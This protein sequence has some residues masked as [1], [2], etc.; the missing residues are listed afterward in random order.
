MDLTLNNFK[1][2]KSIKLSKSE[3]LEIVLEVF[4]TVG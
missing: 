3:I 1:S 4:N 2:T